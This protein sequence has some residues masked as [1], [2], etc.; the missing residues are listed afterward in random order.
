M[1]GSPMKLDVQA[2]AVMTT[3]PRFVAN[4]RELSCWSFCP[5]RNVP[6]GLTRPKE[7]VVLET[8]HCPSKIT[9]AGIVTIMVPKR[10]RRRND[11]W[12]DGFCAV[13]DRFEKRGMTPTHLG[14]SRGLPFGT[15]RGFQTRRCAEN[16]MRCQYET[17]DRRNWVG[18]FV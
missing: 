8:M 9:G 6:R 14:L 16:R 7:Q 2:T 11:H 18:G 4:V 3:V 1:M 13:C 10:C 15:T 17:N 5:G 12:A